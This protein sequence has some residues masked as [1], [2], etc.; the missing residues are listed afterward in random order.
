MEEAFPCL[1]IFLLK[2]P[3]PSLP[4]NF[5]FH[6]ETFVENST[7]SHLLC[8]KTSPKSVSVLELDQELIHYL[9]LDPS[10]LRSIDMSKGGNAVTLTGFIS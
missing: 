7:K 9:C 6:G 4:D 10:L 5:P 3:V 8:P 2:S 1:K